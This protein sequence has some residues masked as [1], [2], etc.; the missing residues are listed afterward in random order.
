MDSEFIPWLLRKMDS[1]N[2][3]MIKL[4]QFSGVSHAT[5]SLVIGHK[6][7]P[8][9]D[10]CCAIAPAL[11]VDET[12]V[13]WRAGLLRHKPLVMDYQELSPIIEASRKLSEEK[14][15]YLVTIANMLHDGI[16][17]IIIPK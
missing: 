5:I 12:E 4:G 13:L 15:E 8:T 7:N 3:N 17:V 9:R 6:Q 10:F 14:K 1:L 2:L 11:G 16:N